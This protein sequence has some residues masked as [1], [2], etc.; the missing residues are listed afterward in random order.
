MTEAD[1]SAISKAVAL[2]NLRDQV[3]KLE[4]S[5]VI[6]MYERA[7]WSAGASVAETEA[8]IVDA[9]PDATPVPVS[10]TGTPMEGFAAL[11]RTMNAMTEDLRAKAVAQHGASLMQ[12]GDEQGPCP[13]SDD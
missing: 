2:S 11:M 9:A 5:G 6:D 13:E 3:R 12:P 8:V 7:A 4:T 10:S 1:E